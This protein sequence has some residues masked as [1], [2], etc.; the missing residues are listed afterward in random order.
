MSLLAEVLKASSERCGV[1]P[2]DV[3][4]VAAGC[5]SPIGEQAINVA[6][7]A[8]L[9]AGWPESTPAMSIDGGAISS[10]AALMNIA[11]MVDGSAIDLGIAAG[12]ESESR[13]PSGATSGMAVG[14]PFGPLVHQRYEEAE[15][16]AAPGIVAENVARRLGLTRAEFDAWAKQSRQ[17]AENARKAGTFKTEIAEVAKKNDKGVDTASFV[18]EDEMVLTD[19]DGALPLFEREG[20]ITGATFAPPADGAAAVLIANATLAESRNLQALARVVGCR[21]GGTSPIDGDSGADLARQLIK[22]LGL[23]ITDMARIEVH[24][25]TAVTPVALSRDLSVSSDKVNPDG[26]ALAFGNPAGASAVGLV[27]RLAHGMSR[28]EAKY[29]LGVIAGYGGLS[30]AIVLERA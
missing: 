19:V 1:S 30:G 17:R 10:L 23:K 9:A 20:L 2:T 14:K 22:D 21:I 13:V 8:V 25:D 24:E 3:Q 16:L 4:H 18:V 28:S 29:G 11:S 15:G 5:A 27:T 26:G 7:S 6:R 12:I